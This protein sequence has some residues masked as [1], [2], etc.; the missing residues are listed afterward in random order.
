MGAQLAAHGIRVHR[1]TSISDESEA[2]RAALDESLS[3]VD[4]VLI[5]GGLGPTR[6]D[7]T[8]ETLADYFDTQLVMDQ[9]ILERI[10][11]WFAGR[12]FEMLDVNRHQAMLPE[13]CKVLVN[14]RG[15]AMGMWFERDAGKKVVV[16]MPGVPYEM[17]GLMREE[18]LPRVDLHW[19]LPTR[20]RRT[21]L[22]QGV[23]ESYLSELVWDWE[24]RLESRGVSIA[25]LPA[26]G[27]VRVRLS[28]VDAVAS[29]AKERVE[30]EVADFLTLAGSHVVSDQD[31]SLGAAVVRVLTRRKM[32]LATAE[33]CTGGAIASSIT[34]VPGSSA[35]FMGSV[36]AYDNRVKQEMLGVSS[37]SLEEHGA[38][39]EEVV[40]QMAQGARKRLRTD[41]AV[42]TSGV[43]GPS[44]GTEEKPVGTVWIAL[45]GPS[46]VEAKCLS[47][48][49]S[50][51]RNIERSMREALAWI[52]RSVK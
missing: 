30:A 36:V 10:T 27:Q 23:G 4:F 28:A 3:R 44:G 5:T 24:E 40:V 20:Y 16:S 17:K 39:S 2:I 34:S 9:A 7:I 14:P 32:T 41:Y 29:K 22:T 42:A 13:A 35:M 43:A 49:N 45:A 6:D 26:P 8:K 46:G 52:I 31:E 25:Y 38:V 50:R 18:V 47:L 48:G 11:Q 51:D 12:G 33:S 15:T 37:V 1:I 21:L 19:A